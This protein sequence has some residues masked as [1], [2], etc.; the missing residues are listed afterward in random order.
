MGA[1]RGWLP[2]RAGSPIPVGGEDAAAVPLQ[3]KM[4]ATITLTQIV[5]FASANVTTATRKN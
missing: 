2:Q 5:N 1:T 3:K 4:R